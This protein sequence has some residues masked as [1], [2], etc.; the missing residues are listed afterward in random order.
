MSLFT[1]SE[2]LEAKDLEFED[3]PVPEW[4]AGKEVRLMSLTGT[5]RDSFEDKSLVQKGANAKM[6]LVNMR[7][8]LLAL[9]IVDENGK[10]MFS[11]IDVNLL[12]QKNAKVLERLFSKAQEMNGMTE[13]DVEDLTEGFSEGPNEDSISD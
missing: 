5:Q 8:R 12:G 9:C 6:N 7:A 13:K 4:G 1:K 11:D 10:R 3:V 2:I